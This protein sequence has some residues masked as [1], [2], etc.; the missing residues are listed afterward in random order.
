MIITQTP[1]R[2]SFMGGGTDFHDYYK[3]DEGIVI[4]SAIDKY[5]FV[6]LKKRFDK[7]IRVGYTNTE[8]VNSVS[9][10]QHELVR[11]SL[12][13]VGVDS[14]IEINTMGDIPSSG[15]GLGSS[16]T[17]TVGTLNALHHYLNVLPTQK[18]LAMEACEIE[19][20]KLHK[21][22]GKQDQYIAAFGG[23][24]AI[25]FHPDDTVTV[26]SIELDK[27][28]QRQLNHNLLLFYTNSTRQ[29]ATILKEQKEKINRN[30]PILREMKKLTFEGKR[31]LEAKLFDDFG[32]MLNEYWL[33]K[34]SL[35]SKIS[36]STIDDIYQ[37][38]LN[39][40]AFGGKITGAGGGGFLLLYCPDENQ[41]AVRKALSGLKE[42]PFSFENDGSKVILNYR[43]FS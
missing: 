28:S 5:I 12:S 25:R 3:Q 18:Q 34:K 13:L 2:I 30:L 8:L 43:R 39:A 9:E 35:A 32:Y 27:E 37:K 31:L 33:L 40:G 36:N 29:S 14:Q 42:L 16:S 38:A 4:S 22:I 24:R 19:I 26:E 6:V 10:I 15:S 17:V 41:K 21:P 7:L 23:L 1:L 20:N 11:E